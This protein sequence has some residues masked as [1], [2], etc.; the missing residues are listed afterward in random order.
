M[1]PGSDDDLAILSRLNKAS[2]ISLFDGQLIDGESLREQRAQS[3]QSSKRLPLSASSSLIIWRTKESLKDTVAKTQVD[4]IWAGVALISIARD[5]GC[6][7]AR[8][9]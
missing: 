2:L 7:N 1:T 4:C 6:D 8:C 5:I 3:A 9:C